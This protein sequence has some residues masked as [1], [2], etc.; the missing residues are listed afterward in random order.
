MKTAPNVP[1]DVL[2][3][4]ERHAKETERPLRAVVVDR[5]RCAIAAG[6]HRCQYELPDLRVGDP[7]SPD[8]FGMYSWPELRD[9]VYGNRGVR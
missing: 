9:L 3:R 1:D 5:Q 8:P 7:N 4:A 2:A 6:G